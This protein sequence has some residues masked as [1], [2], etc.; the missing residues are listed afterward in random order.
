MTV[1]LR[2]WQEAALDIVIEIAKLSSRPSA[3][4]RARAR[5]MD[6]ASMSDATLETIAS[7]LREVGVVAV[8]RDITPTTPI[9]ADPTDVI[10]LRSGLPKRTTVGR[11]HA[12]WTDILGQATH[13]TVIAVEGVLDLYFS[14][15]STMPEHRGHHLHEHD[16]HDHHETRRLRDV[17]PSI[18]RILRAEK[19]DVWIITFY[20]VLTSLLGLVVPLSSQ[21]IVNAVALGVF[22]QQL[23]VLCIVVF[24]AMVATAII[25][26]FERYVIDMVQRRVFVNTAFDVIYRVPHFTQDAVRSVYTPELVNRFFDVMTVQKS[27]GKFLLEGINAVLVLLTGLIVLGIYHPFFL[28]YDFIFLL[29]IP[30]LVFVLGRGAISTAIKVSKK[31]YITAGWLE[32]VARTQLG[33]KLTGA[34]PYT[35]ARINEIATG[36]VEA[37]HKHYIVMARQILGSYLF[38]GMATVGVLALGGVLV[39]EQAISLGQLVAAEIIIILILGAMEK[40]IA[41]FDQYYDLIAALDKLS[42]ITDQPLEEVGGIPVPAMTSGGTVDVRDLRFSYGSQSVLKGVTLHIPSGARVS[43]VGESGAG[44]STLAQII[45]GL[46]AP[47]SGS[48]EVNGIDTRVADLKTLRMRVGYVFPENQI[49]PGTILE[50]ITLGRRVSA[51]DIRW[52]LRMAHLEDIV[53]SMDDGLHTRISTTG[54]NLSFGMRR[55]VLFARMILSRPDILII[56][57]AFEGIEDATKLDMLDDLMAW[58]HWTIINITHDPEVVHRTDVVHVLADGR[59]CESGTPDE[60]RAKAGSFCTLFPGGARG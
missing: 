50:N 14:P 25:A 6:I 59:I 41:Q 16:H 56:D 23:V 24:L 11:G 27:I 43:L 54:E 60:L 44:K 35:F 3:F 31:K 5:I 48:V 7:T 37:K 34:T 19:R 22:S 8:V 13:C 33:I 21:A 47:S 57:E 40:L 4:I 36:Y 53:R 12:Q 45:L 39:I 20:S 38:K 17:W 2:Q 51:D 32:D 15:D 46:D 42:M 55:R 10:C 18:K 1:D 49:I 58:P 9:P 26:V 52:A 29:F 28:L 30:V